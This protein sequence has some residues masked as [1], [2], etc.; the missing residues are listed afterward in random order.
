MLFGEYSSP[1][2]NESYAQKSHN[3]SAQV[4]ERYGP[5]PKYKAQKAPILDIF[6]FLQYAI[7]YV[8]SHVGMAEENNT[9]QETTLQSLNQLGARANSIF[10]MLPGDSDFE[11]GLPPNNFSERKRLSYLNW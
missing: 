10:R 5:N 6:P 3:Y 1:R 8:Y 4:P 11:P 9:P 2:S 7:G